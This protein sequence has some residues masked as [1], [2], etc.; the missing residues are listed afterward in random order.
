MRLDTETVK[1]ILDRIT[2]GTI[3]RVDAHD[4]VVVEADEIHKQVWETAVQARAS[5]V[6]VNLHVTDRVAV[7]QEDPILRTMIKWISNWKVQ[8]LNHLLGDAMNIGRERLSFE[9]GK[10]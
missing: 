3:G 10:S 1:S 5:I 2:V 7:E 9:K 8:D 6:C 4:P